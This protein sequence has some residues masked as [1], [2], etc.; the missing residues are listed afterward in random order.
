VKV[1]VGKLTAYES[2]IVST[3]VDLFNEKAKVMQDCLETFCVTLNHPG[4]SISQ[5]GISQPLGLG[6]ATG[7]VLC[8]GPE[9]LE[10]ILRTCSLRSVSA[11]A[12]IRAA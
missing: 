1:T 4:S 12:G 3:G 7:L 6:G 5:K 2:W 9:N 10:E 11:K 8:T